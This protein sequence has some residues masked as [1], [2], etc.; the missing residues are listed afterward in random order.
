MSMFFSILVPVYNTS[1]YLRECLDSILEQSFSDFELVLLN[2]GSTDDSGSI[3]DEYA[4]RDQRI[5]VIHK[6]NEGLMMT[7]RRGFREARGDYFIC[8]DSDDKFW[9]SRALERIRNMIAATGCDMVL[10]NYMYGAG[11]G[12]SEQA[13]CLLEY[14]TGTVFAG[15]AKREIYEK[16]LV[17]SHLN[18]MWLKCV[19]RNVVDVDVD[20]SQWK[21]EICRAEDRFQTYPML[22]NAEKIA[23][24][25]EP[26]YYYRW[27]PG[28]IGN[29]PKLKYC[30]AYKC[31]YTRENAYLALWPVSDK[32]KE[33]AIRRRLTAY[34]DVL[35]SG[36]FSCK[37][38]GDTT[39]WKNFAVSLAED[40]FFR[41]ILDGCD[42]S[43]VLKYYRL[44]HSLICR[45][46]LRAAIFVIEFTSFIS[47]RKHRRNTNV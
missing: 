43:K 35:C 19:A 38:S 9:D 18:N 30:N 11:G 40:P 8:V 3:C 33:K 14:E 7:R 42:R 4:A 22:S 28:S 45:R 13:S 12:R 15:E 21:A 6:D 34:V 29:K 25:R 27:T 24:I 47:E 46:Q 36:Y 37:R 16:M 10:Y 1:A 20:Y 39:A 23:Y 32:V 2:D 17:T 5:R 44:L 41:E 31:M 26:L